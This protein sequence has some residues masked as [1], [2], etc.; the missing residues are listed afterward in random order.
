MHELHT[1]RVPIIIRPHEL[2]RVPASRRPSG[3]SPSGLSL[4]RSAIG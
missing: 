3:K 2:H 4:S 1:T